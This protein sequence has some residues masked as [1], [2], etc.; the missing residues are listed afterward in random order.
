MLPESARADFI[1]QWLVPFGSSS[2]L[3]GPVIAHRPC[4]VLPF[5]FGTECR[6]LCAKTGRADD[7]CHWAHPPMSKINLRHRSP[8]RAQT[9]KVKSTC[10]GI[11]P[12]NGWNDSKTAILRQWRDRP[13]RPKIM[14]QKVRPC[15][16]TLDRLDRPL[17]SALSSR[18]NIPQLLQHTDDCAMRRN[19]CLAWQTDDDRAICLLRETQSI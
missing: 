6:T 2:P 13:N 14:Q 1:G 16:A 9:G 3:A 18:G 7:G 5:R 11:L 19:T 4:K 15:V 17:P 12:S 8:P 10:E